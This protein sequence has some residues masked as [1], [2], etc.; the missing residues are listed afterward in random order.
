MKGPL[1]LEWGF[2]GGRKGIYVRKGGVPHK[3]KGA[4]GARYGKKGTKGK[5]ETGRKEIE[6]QRRRGQPLIETT[7]FQRG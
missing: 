1:S 4:K 2:T 3:G 5:E 7:V 6:R